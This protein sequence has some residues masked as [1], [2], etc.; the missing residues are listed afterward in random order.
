M[1]GA[2][3]KASRPARFKSSTRQGPDPDEIAQS[4][5]NAFTRRRLGRSKVGA[6]FI[7]HRP[8]QGGHFGIR[9]DEL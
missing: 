1:V 2:R 9:I 3:V 4:R 8:Q 6:D 5:G 7:D